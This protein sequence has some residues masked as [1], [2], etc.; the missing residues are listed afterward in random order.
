M[1][2]LTYIFAMLMLA[3]SACAQ[4]EYRT[5]RD[6]LKNKKEDAVGNVE[7]CLKNDK[8]KEDPELLHYGVEAWL[9]VNSNLNRT[10]YLKN[11][12]DTTRLFN[13]IYSIYNYAVRCDTMETFV[14]KK[15]GKKKVSYKYRSS[16]GSL[17][18]EQYVNLYNGGQYMLLKKDFANAY[19]FFSMYYDIRTTPLFGKT[20]VSK[21]DSLNMIR[22]AYWATVC[23][24]QLNDNTKFFKYNHAALLDTTYRQKE[25]ELTARI[26]KTSKDTAAMVEILKT[27]AK[28]FPQLDYFFTNL[29]DYYNNKGKFDDA[30]ALADNILKH[31]PRSVMA[32][33]GRSLVLLKMKNYDDCIALATSIIQSDSTY[34]GAYYN[35]G[36]AYLA[37]ATLLHDKVKS[38]MSLS[39]IRNIKREED[40]LLRTAL[41]YLEHYRVLNPNAVDWWGRPLYNIY[42]ALNMGDK[43]EEVE[44]LIANAEKAKEEAAKKK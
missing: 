12:Y 40:K 3:T 41:P 28:E 22:A 43:F 4:K 23:A 8:L 16:H 21:S 24:Y 27:G 33:Y 37:K 9:L 35:V 39:E 7:N 30:M 44:K 10:A 5:I 18:R 36:A 17:L 25:L 42:L 13:S 34:S 29:I 6:N 14:A 1:R 2:R 38:N 20:K 11:K 19:N 26:Y 15:K 31:D 32:Q